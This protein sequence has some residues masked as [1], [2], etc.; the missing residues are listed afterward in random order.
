MANNV[1]MFIPAFGNRITTATYMTSS[2]IIME[3]YNK[4]IGIGTSALSFPDIAELRSMILTLFYDTMPQMTHLLFID[5]DMGFSPQLVTDMLL[6]DEPLVGAIYPHRRLPQ[7]WVGSGDGSPTTQRRAGFMAVEGIGGGGMLIRR[8]VVTRM[9]AQMPEIVDTRIDLHPAKD[10]LTQGGATRL[11][12]AF[13]KLDLPERGVV[14]EDLSFC[15]RAKRCGIQTWGA[16]GH[17]I[18]HVGDFDFAARFLDQVEQADQAAALAQR[19]Q[20]QLEK[21]APT[22]HHYPLAPSL[23]PTTDSVDNPSSLSIPSASFT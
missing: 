22:V 23:L 10:I 6:F 18:S 13:E 19:Q 17:R 2:S 15:I 21:P 11:I 1:F 14:S 5:A 7:S 3:C 4:G 8:D 9:L 20:Q 16:I 12:R